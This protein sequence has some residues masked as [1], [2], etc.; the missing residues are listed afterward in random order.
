MS[1]LVGPTHLDP[2]DASALSPFAREVPDVATQ[3]A[4]HSPVTGVAERDAVGVLIGAAFR[5]RYEVVVFELADVVLAA[6][7]TEVETHLL[8]MYM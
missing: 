5:L 4:V 6:G 3:H 1:Q 8:L 7:N 2:R